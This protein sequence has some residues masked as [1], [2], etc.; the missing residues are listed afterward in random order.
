M[1]LDLEEANREM[2]G[3]HRA[4]ELRGEDRGIGGSGSSLPM[5]I[6]LAV[7]RSLSIVR[8]APPNLRV[9]CFYGFW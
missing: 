4:R 7:L 1:S 3:I 6:S 8:H 9:K 2:S 5:A